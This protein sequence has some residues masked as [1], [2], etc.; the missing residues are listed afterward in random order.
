MA[1]FAV[2]GGHRLRQFFE[3]FAADFRGFRIIWCRPSKE[4]PV[5]LEE[6]AWFTYEKE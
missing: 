3:P 2:P 1:I 4:N 5:Q 6:Y